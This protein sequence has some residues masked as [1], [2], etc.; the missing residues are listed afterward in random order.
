M[1]TAPRFFVLS[2]AALSL[3]A[4]SCSGPDLPDLGKVS[5]VVTLEGE[6]YPN[7]YV[8]FSPT[9]GRPSEAVTDSTGRYELIYMPRVKGAQVGDHTVSITTQYQAPENPDSAPPFVEPL[10]PK[11]NVRSTLSATVGPGDNTVDFAL[12]KK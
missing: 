7:A 5:G 3:L 11:Y 1:H 8:V 9:K 6:P 12:T 10:P 2:L 4:A